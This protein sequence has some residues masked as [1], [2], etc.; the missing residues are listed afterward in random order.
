[1]TQL[2][3]MTLC[4]QTIVL[5][6]ERALFW[7][8]AR[9]LVVADPHFGKAQVFREKGIPLPEGTTA[10]DL[11]RLSALVAAFQP[12]VLL[13]L[14]DLVHG[15]L[16]VRESLERRVTRWRRKHPQLVLWLVRG[17]HDRRAGRPPGPFGFDQVAMEL[18]RD[19]FRFTHAPSA[20]GPGYGMAGHLHPAVTLSG[21]GRQKE[22]LPCFWFGEQGAVLPAFGSFTGTRAVRPSA[23]DRLYVIVDDE[24]R[25]V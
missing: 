13:I 17:N 23:G 14:G 12:K 7:K 2:L 8:D 10:R 6:S 25:E 22:T 18:V 5:H 15:P 20:N 19:P 21:A 24:V 1:M 11:D 4:G 9:T 16:A 3:Q